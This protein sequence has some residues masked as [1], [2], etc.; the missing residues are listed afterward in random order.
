MGLL[1]NKDYG[2]FC[3][4]LYA[5]NVASKAYIYSTMNQP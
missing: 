1:E 4:T 5:E 2:D 3:H